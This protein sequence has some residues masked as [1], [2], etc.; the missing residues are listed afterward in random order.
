[1]GEHAQTGTYTLEVTDTITIMHI[2]LKKQLKVLSFYFAWTLVFGILMFLF[3][4]EP[5]AF[6]IAFLYWAVITTLPVLVL[7][8]SYYLANH[9]DHVEISSDELRI[10]RKNQNIFLRNTDI[11]KIV[12][13]KSRRL[14]QKMQIHPLEVYFLVKVFAKNGTRFTLTCLISP[15]ID[16]DVKIIRGVSLERKRTVFIFPG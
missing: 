9:Y 2:T 12:I 6:L 1:M 16:E 13:Y 14:E 8:I 5:A 11:D 10:K 3:R 4:N 7:H 15:T